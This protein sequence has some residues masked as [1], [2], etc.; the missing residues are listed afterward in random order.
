MWLYGLGLSALLFVIVLLATNSDCEP[1]LFKVFF[2]LLTS[3]FLQLLSP[4]VGFALAMAWIY[5][6]ADEVVDVVIMLGAVTDLSH[7]V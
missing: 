1:Y 7:Q 6:I 2:G 3:N 4:Y 5:L